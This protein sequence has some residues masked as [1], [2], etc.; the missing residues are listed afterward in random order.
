[1]FLTLPNELI[2]KILKKYP[3]EFRRLVQLRGVC[4]RLWDIIEEH[5]LRHYTE[6]RL[7]IAIDQLDG[8]CRNAS[9]LQVLYLYN[10]EKFGYFDVCILNWIIFAFTNQIMTH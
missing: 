10:H 8:W 7:Y 4:R 1:M 6:M 3:M 5:F 9:S 2:V